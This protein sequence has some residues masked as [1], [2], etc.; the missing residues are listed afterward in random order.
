MENQEVVYA[1]VDHLTPEQRSEARKI[2]QA[3]NHRS[4]WPDNWFITCEI[5]IANVI[6]DAQRRGFIEGVEKSIEIAADMDASPNNAIEESIRAALNV[7]K[8]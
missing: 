8:K 4:S 3:C 5:C 1:E 7:P 2:A 6:I